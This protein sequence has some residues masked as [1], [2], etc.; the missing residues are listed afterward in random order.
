MLARGAQ[1]NAKED[2]RLLLLSSNL[3]ADLS[4]YG[5]NLT[6]S[7]ASSY[8][9]NSARAALASAREVYVRI[10]LTAAEANRVLIA[11]HNTALTNLTYAIVTNGS[12]QIEVQAGAGTS[13]WKGPVAPASD[14]SIAMSTRVNPDTTG[15]SDAL[16]STFVVYDHTV[17]EWLAIDQATHAAPTTASNYTLSVGGLL[18]GGFIVNAPTN[19]PTRVRV[20]S[21]YHS[22]TEFGEDW[23]AARTA[24]AGDLADEVEEPLGPDVS[25]GLGS[26]PELVGRAQVGFA[27]A[28]S[29]AV[30]RRA[31][32]PLVNEVYVDPATGGGGTG[33]WPDHWLRTA[34]GSANYQMPLPFLRWVPVPAGASHAYVRVHVRSW[35]T[36]GAAVPIG[37]RVYA[38]NRPPDVA[39][40]G[41]APSP[42]LE[43]AYRGEVLTVDHTSTGT[44]EWL[45]LGLL[46]LPKFTGPAKG[47]TDTAHLALAYAVD[48][49]ASSANDANA[50]FQ[51]VA[52]HVRPVY[53]W[54]PG[55]LY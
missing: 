15:A 49:A 24:Y 48:P 26:S 41:A 5:T 42:P 4:Q 43:T 18:S 6:A 34:P 23:V 52:W 40:I 31:W 46:R 22:S 2:T 38:M 28:H 7:G 37:I 51:I 12:G 50:R 14:L 30:Q 3:T 33:G 29:A 54:T 39:Q 1:T 20:S 25:C 36:S 44:G 21:S 53:V 55:G 27:A 35:V 16:I 11:H 45:E 19:A 17:G 13:I 32:S 8:E 9:T 47:W 10:T